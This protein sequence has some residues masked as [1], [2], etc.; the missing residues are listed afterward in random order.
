MAHLLNV[1]CVHRVY[2]LHV[3]ACMSSKIPSWDGMK[4]A[5]GSNLL[6]YFSRFILLS[7][8]QSS[9]NF[10]VCWHNYMIQCH[11]ELLFFVIF[12]DMKHMVIMKICTCISISQLKIT[13]LYGRLNLLKR[14]QK[15]RFIFCF[16]RVTYFLIKWRERK[17]ARNDERREWRMDQIN[18][19]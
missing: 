6:S 13:Q 11:N 1:P 5:N 7:M 17:C 2:Q 12:T 8:C 14:C 16:E 4:S 19:Q 18:I 15:L 3:R 10:M 9:M